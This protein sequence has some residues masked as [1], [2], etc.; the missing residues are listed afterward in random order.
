VGRGEASE[1]ANVEMEGVLA[2]NDGLPV[3]EGVVG[4]G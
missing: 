2:V 4:R 3:G 1:P